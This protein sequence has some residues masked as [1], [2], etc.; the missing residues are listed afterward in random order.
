MSK[1]DSF[2]DFLYK[3]NK[4]FIVKMEFVEIPGKKYAL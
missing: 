3:N 2:K 4:S 1:S